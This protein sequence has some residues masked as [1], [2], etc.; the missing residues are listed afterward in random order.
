MAIPP[1]ESFDDRS[2]GRSWTALV[3]RA[4]S[5]PPPDIDVRA[6]VLAALAAQ[7]RVAPVVT[8]PNGFAEFGRLFGSPLSLVSYGTCTCAFGVL[9]LWSAIG[10]LDPLSRLTLFGRLPGWL[11]TVLT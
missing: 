4:R 5:A 2:S 1:E 9:A 7:R 6:G 11:L 3:A 10:H 8:S